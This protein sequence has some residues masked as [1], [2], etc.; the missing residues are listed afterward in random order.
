MNAP[1]EMSHEEVLRVKLEVLRREHRDLDEAISAL[2][3]RT[4]P[5][6]LTLRRLK[7]QKLALKDQITRIEDELT[8]D[9]I[10]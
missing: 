3:E 8:P 6:Q 7:K 2:S 4:R 5:D 9:I 1:T 10:A